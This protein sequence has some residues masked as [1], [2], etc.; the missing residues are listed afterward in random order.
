MKKYY[1]TNYETTE[2][3]YFATDAE[4]LA[5]SQKRNRYDKNAS[6]K[7]W[8]EYGQAIYGVAIAR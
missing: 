5:E 6:W 2:V 8:D 7:A 1:L 4:A 3:A